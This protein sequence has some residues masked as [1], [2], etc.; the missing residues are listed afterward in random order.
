MILDFLVEMSINLKLKLILED[1]FKTMEN[2]DLW[3][4]RID[5]LLWDI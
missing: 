4:T 1:F 3:K 5:T 2:L